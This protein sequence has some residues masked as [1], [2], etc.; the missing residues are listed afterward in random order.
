MRLERAVG[1][2]LVGPGQQP[3]GLLEAV[4]VGEA[5]RAARRRPGAM[6]SVIDSV[7]PSPGT[8]RYFTKPRSPPSFG[9][10]ATSTPGGSRYQRD[11]Y[12][13]PA[14]DGPSRAPRRR[15]SP[16]QAGTGLAP[17][18]GGDDDVGGAAPSRRRGGRRSTIGEPRRPVAGR[19]DEA[20][21]AG[22]GRGCSTP[23]SAQRRRGAAPTRRWCAARRAPPGPRRRAGARRGRASAAA[24]CTRRRAGRRARRGSARA[25]RRRCGRGSRGSGGP[26]A[27]PAARRRTPPRRRR[28]AG[29]GSRSSTVTWWPARPSA[30]AVA[31]PPTPPPTTTTRWAP[32]LD[33]APP[34]AGAPTRSRRLATPVA[35]RP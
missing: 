6:A 3:A 18:G 33:H 2:E 12:I 31:S 9:S 17:A 29:S 27:R 15:A 13:E 20:G 22:A 24:S 11:R 8:P 21:D 26:A 25:A 10:S 35:R 32:S 34:T 30:S 23:G 1:E 16:S 5:P 19:G 28:S 14:R 4:G 7:S